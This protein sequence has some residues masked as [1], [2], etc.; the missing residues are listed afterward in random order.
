MN[1]SS[2][3]FRMIVAVVISLIIAA[4]IGYG[5]L[6]IMAHFEVQGGLAFAGFLYISLM[7][8]A[9]MCPAVKYCEKGMDLL[10]RR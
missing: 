1:K 5:A 7:V 2:I 6:V 4:A 8:V 10:K 3:V 9:I